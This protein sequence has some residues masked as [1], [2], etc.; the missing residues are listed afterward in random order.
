MR[1]TEPKLE[2]VW[3]NVLTKERVVVKEILTI[4]H[5]DKHPFNNKSAV[6]FENLTDKKRYVTPL[7]Q[8]EEQVET[9]AEPEVGDTFFEYDGD[10]YTHEDQTLFYVH[11]TKD[12]TYYVM[13][14]E[15]DIFRTQVYCN[16]PKNF[17]PV[18]KRERYKRVYQNNLYPTV[19]EIRQVGDMTY[20]VTGVDVDK[21]RIYYTLCGPGFLFKTE[22]DPEKF[23]QITANSTK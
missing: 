11:K 10:R 17:V 4:T 1:E 22:D 9:K 7:S 12:R 2:S 14:N 20:T 23:A 15:H 5:V 18:T 6:V 3:L 8:W 16:I 13:G 21:Y 19:G